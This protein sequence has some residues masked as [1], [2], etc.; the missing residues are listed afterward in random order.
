MNRGLSPSTLQRENARFRGGGG[1][2][3]GNAATGLCPAFLDITTRRVYL[4][5]FADG[6]PAPCHLL[7]GLPARLIAARDAAGRVLRIKATVVSGFAC[8]GRFY[9]R[10]EAAALVPATR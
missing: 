9:S 7:D 2:S 6:R 1:V 8:D 4:S 10:D 5:R 3:A